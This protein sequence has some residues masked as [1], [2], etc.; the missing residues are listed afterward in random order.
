MTAAAARD[1]A[2]AKRLAKFSGIASSAAIDLTGKDEN[3]R[4]SGSGA[5]P[6]QTSEYKFSLLANHPDLSFP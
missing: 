6:A 1:E 4:A 2:I 5:K 3:S